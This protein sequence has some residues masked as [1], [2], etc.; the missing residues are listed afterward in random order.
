MKKPTLRVDDGEYELYHSMTTTKMNTLDWSYVKYFSILSRSAN[1]ATNHMRLVVS[2]D[3]LDP[4]SNLCTLVRQTIEPATAKNKLYTI[5]SSSSWFVA[6]YDDQMFQLSE[7][8][9]WST[10]SSINQM[11]AWE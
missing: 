2:T 1:I 10:V 7:L 6:I 4:N 5:G 8:S 11:C 9:W 3:I